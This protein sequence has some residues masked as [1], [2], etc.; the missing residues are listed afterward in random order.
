MGT[1]PI[2]ESDFDCLTEKC[3]GGLKTWLVKLKV[4]EDGKRIDPSTAGKAAFSQV[5]KMLRAKAIQ[6]RIKTRQVYFNESSMQRSRRDII[7]EG[8]YFE[9]YEQKGRSTRIGQ[10]GAQK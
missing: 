2:F 8:A 4:K 5:G 9:C 3:V 10:T 6:T 1:H 7:D